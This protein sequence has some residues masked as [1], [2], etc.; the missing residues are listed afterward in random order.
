MA[1]G[2][3]AARAA[4]TRLLLKSDGFADGYYYT[5]DEPTGSDSRYITEYLP[6]DTDPSSFVTR[7][8]VSLVNG[9][10]TG[11]VNLQADLRSEDPNNPGYPLMTEVGLIASADPNQPVACLSN[12]RWTD[13]FVFA[14]G[15]GVPAPLGKFYLTVQPPP[16]QIGVNA[17]G[18]AM[19][20]SSPPTGATKYYL[21]SS[22]RFGDS[23]WNH[24]AEIEVFESGVL[25]LQTRWHGSVRYPGDA[26]RPIVFARRP[27]ATGPTD[28]FVSVSVLIDN[29]GQDNLGK[30]L[31]LYV[32][33]IR[34]GSRRSEGWKQI[35]HLFR[36]VVFGQEI[37]KPIVISPG[38]TLLELE[39]PLLI[40]DR[41][42]DLLPRNIRFR[43]EVSDLE[44]GGLVDDFEEFDLGLR[45]FS[46]EPDD[47]S[48]EGLFLVQSPTRTGDALSVRFPAIDL[49]TTSA[50][51]ISSI[52][53]AGGELGAD[54]LPGFDAVEL[55]LEDPILV[56]APDLSPL[57]LLRR[58]GAADGRGEI[59]LGPVMTELT[60]DI[61]DLVVEPLEEPVGN[62]WAQVLLNPGDTVQ[63][64]L[65]TFLG[66]DGSG[67]TLL[68]DSYYSSQGS[69]L[70]GHDIT[71]NYMIRLLLD[72]RKE[73]QNGGD[74]RSTSTDMRLPPGGFI[75][76]GDGILVNLQAWL[77]EGQE[78]GR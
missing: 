34:R 44:G 70:Y 4:G 20:T 45:P 13:F 42:L 64:N 55:R 75:S 76:T 19:D 56:D 50:F 16:G 1:A 2:P 32:E 72:G 43:A 69:S 61:D 10:L 74:E 24:L 15:A 51:T 47:G 77:D 65:G 68:T 29:L 26:G 9:G 46:G 66:G 33:K 39:L 22:D 53:V 7:I 12:H 35:T 71:Q 63:P 31:E 5:L 41:H 30:R 37:P 78:S 36:T 73:P 6:G 54:E 57:G 59:V 67:A 18:V 62:L 3:Q 11:A 17:C 25:D 14:G 60:L 38:R 40:P 27:S 28:D 49:P 23:P 21:S 48:G 52:Q 8:R 58:V